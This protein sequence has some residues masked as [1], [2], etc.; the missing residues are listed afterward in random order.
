VGYGVTAIA[1]NTFRIVWTGDA[2]V[3][4]TGYREFAGSLWTTGHI[5]AI[6][7]GCGASAC[8]L[9]DG[10]YVSAMLPTSQG[11]RIDWDTY[12]STGFDGF[13]VV[14]DGAP[15]FLDVFVD[16]VRHPELVYLPAADEGGAIES[17]AV[18]PFGVVTR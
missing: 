9:E 17:P 18:A 3:N 1:P 4:G 2:A 8:P 5:V 6:T 12:A 14:T 10:D 16:G 15:A 11:E 7:P 13:D